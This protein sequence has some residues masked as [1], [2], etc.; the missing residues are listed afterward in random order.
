MET[1]L[2]TLEPKPK[3]GT[4]GEHRIFN[5]KW[6]ENL[7]YSGDREGCDIYCGHCNHW[8][9]VKGTGILFQFMNCKNCNQSFLKKSLINTYSYGNYIL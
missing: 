5:G 6:D 9:T 4:K 1:F 2:N 3:H 8:N 7:Q